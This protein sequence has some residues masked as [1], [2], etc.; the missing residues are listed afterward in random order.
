[1]CLL[2]SPQGWYLPGW[3]LRLFFTSICTLYSAGFL[4]ESA[5]LR[6]FAIESPRQR[7]KVMGRVSGQG[8]GGRLF[9][10]NSVKKSSFESERK[11]P[12]V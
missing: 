1:M 8:I 11:P 10:F 12:S 2:V 6:W 5:K 3:V 4:L 9:D 7:R